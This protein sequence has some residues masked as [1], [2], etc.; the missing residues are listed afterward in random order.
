MEKS[1]D[2]NATRE[3]YL[4]RLISYKNNIL[5]TMNFIAIYEN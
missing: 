5:R 2:I 3:Y 4:Q 1:L